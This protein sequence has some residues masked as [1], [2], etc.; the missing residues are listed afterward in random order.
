MEQA[1][2]GK[3]AI[4]GGQRPAAASP[5]GPA[6]GATQGDTFYF[7]PHTHWEGAVF[8][9]RAA[10]LDMGLPH[11]LAALRLLERHPDYRFVLDQACYVEP[12][13][14][15][16]PEEEEAF[17][18]FLREGRLAIAGGMDVMPDVNMPGGESLV[19]QVVYG[20][21]FFRRRLGVDPHIAWPLDTFGHHAQMPQLLGLAGYRSMW[22][23]RGVS[24][25]E[26]PAEFLWEGIDGTRIAAYWLP[27]GYAVTYGSPASEEAFA[28]F[29][30]ERFARLAPFARGPGRVG[31][32]GADVCEPEEHVPALVAAFNRRPDRPFDLRLATPAEYEA[33][34]AARGGEL[35]VVRGELNPIF[36]GTYSSRIE[37]KQQTRELEVLLTAAEKLGVVLGWLGLE[38][39]CG[40]LWR[41]WEPM[42]FNQTHDL[43]SGVM[44]DA[45]YEDTLESFAFSRRLAAGEV[46]QR[47]RRLAGQIDT[48]GEGIPLVVWNPLGWERTDLAEVEVSLV[49]QDG[50]GEPGAAPP[51]SGRSAGDTGSAGGADAAGHAAPAVG[52]EPPPEPALQLVDPDGS[53]VPVQVLEAR[54]SRGGALLGARIAFVARDVPALGHGVYH[55]RATR[56]AGGIDR[57]AAPGSGPPHPSGSPPAGQACAGGP[58]RSA[59]A[60]A[61]PCVLE[62]EHYRLEVDARTGAITRVSVKDGGWEALCAPGN[63]VA[64]EEDHGDLWEPY[65]PLDGGSR[66]AM[67]VR[68]PAPEPG[69]AVLSTDQPGEPG[70]VR[71]G[72]VLTEVTVEHPF[73]EQG[74]FRTTV[75]LCAGLPRVEVHTAILNHDRFVRYRALF[76]TTMP[77]GDSVHEIPFGASVRPDGIEFPAQNWVDLGGP[78]RGVALLN[79]GLPGNNAA[80]GAL[81]LSL[82]RCTSIV[83]YGFG[84]GYEPGMSSDSGHEVGQERAFDYALVPHAG[85]WRQAGLFRQGM[86]FVHPLRVQAAAPHPGRLPARWGFLRVSDPRVVVSA[87]KTG[88]EGGA[89][90]RLYEA[91]GQPARQVRVGLAGRP[92]AASE[93][94]LVEDPLSELPLAAD[95]SLHLDLRPFEI[96]T[97]GFR[98]PP[99]QGADPCA[100]A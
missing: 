96:R 10:Y 53:Q 99:E 47:L 62:N 20:K 19:R 80:D 36:Q 82:M 77:P 73:G 76:P 59:H 12:F 65:R 38:A 17:R 49:G 48:Q 61:G 86:E 57:E 43:M 11:I 5:V 8:R 25:W 29:M 23:F 71:Q 3:E 98:F 70:T 31:P 28:A 91:T 81:I 24:S 37:L 13:L 50:T 2:G 69:R 85:D 64:C 52:V 6:P 46:E 39:D 33:A 30:E 21:G 67:A 97:I 35:P 95:G 87:L 88:E 92:V 26:T 14:E 89:V 66:I 9:T 34:V 42:L 4:S 93:V 51:A 22:F 27:H 75:R 40:I 45:V 58:P 54:R 78:D 83:A 18:R 41:A 16:Y 79:R 32:A 60:A 1:N 63:V 55:L 94:N 90:L 44:T 7:I 68:H 56:G 72:P 74:R 100:S 84:G 15:R